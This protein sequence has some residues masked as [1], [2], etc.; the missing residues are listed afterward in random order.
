MLPVLTFGPMA[1]GIIA[2]I[3]GRRS[4]TAR[5]YLA[6]VI[7]VLELGELLYLSYL[8][9]KG[10]RVEFASDALCGLGISM[11]LDGFRVVYGLI[12]AF[13]WMNT[14]IFSREYM[15]HYP[16]TNRYY[17]FFLSTLGATVGVFLS[18]DLFTTFLFFE[19]MSFTSYAW[20][21]HDETK[22]SLRAAGTYLAVAITGGM[23][24]LFGLF[25]LYAYTGT[26]KMDEIHDALTGVIG[27][28]QS[29]AV[30]I[31]VAGACI[32]TGFGAKAGMF[33][34]HIWLPK[35]HP[36]APAPASALLSGI[37]T[38]TGIFGVLIVSSEIFRHNAGFGLVMLIF[39][40]I[41]MFLGA[42]LGIFSINLKRTLAC[43]SMSQIGFILVGIGMQGLLGEENALAIR[44]TALHMVNH[45]LI[46]LVLFMAAGVIYMNIHKLDLNDIKGWGR[47]K[48]ML[49]A[50][51]LVGA[52]SISGVPAFSGYI[53]KTLLHESIVEYINI[54]SEPE[55]MGYY[56]IAE[57]IFLLTGGMTLAYMLKLFIA[58]F[59][60]E[61]P[62]KEEETKRRRYTRP[63]SSAVL[64]LSAFVL[65]V[66]GIWPY[67]L[68]DG[69]AGLMMPFMHGSGKVGMIPYFSPG[70]L[71]GSIIS[72]AIGVII[73]ILIV[74]KLLIAKDED[75]RQVYID[76]WPKWLDLENLVYRPLILY[77]LPYTFAF[78]LRIFDRMA[79]HVISILH[80]SILREVEPRRPLM[81]GNAFT[82]VIGVAVDRT[83]A[84]LNRTF[85]KESPVSVNNEEKIALSFEE[86]VKRTRLASRSV[87]FG[88]MMFSLGFM[89]TLVYL[90]FVLMSH[91]PT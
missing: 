60:E 39:G 6:G 43:S 64:I 35:A 17:L 44:G 38:K 21:A 11:R 88:L 18:A 28:N 47:N 50:V 83:A 74:R 78:I 3:V 29:S 65:F 55:L 23:I 57:F 34:L 20:V 40:L 51:F 46:K 81:F 31:Y 2:Y 33:P 26:L 87:S 15:A 91:V 79:D 85:R 58:I 90:I 27:N 80:R 67:R 76:A 13:M 53:S 62:W 8:A 12:A 24:M 41:T 61:G 7:S 5:D 63:A 22:E 89:F 37:L 32:L 56:R 30:G 59:V 48:P 70:N 75:G 54:L 73:Y 69:I 66:L 49:R 42:L 45:S 1:G 4:K 72:I 9:L 71:K 77:I 82:H 19:I 86:T 25:M 10:S 84:L 14:T 68:M 52:L 36:V 16:R